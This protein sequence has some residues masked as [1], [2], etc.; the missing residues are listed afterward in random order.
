MKNQDVTTQFLHEIST[1]LSGRADC[2]K[3]EYRISIATTDHHQNVQLSI[4]MNEDN[5]IMMDPVVYVFPD[6]QRRRQEDRQTILYHILMEH[7]YDIL[8]RDIDAF[9]N[10]LV[11]TEKLTPGVYL[12]NRYR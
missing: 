9:G 2:S 5:T 3:I 8:Y 6:R 11:N 12:Y 10:I 1:H 7:F 4:D